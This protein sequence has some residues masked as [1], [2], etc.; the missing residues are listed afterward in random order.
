MADEEN[1]I[2][3]PPLTLLSKDPKEAFE[4]IKQSRKSMLVKTLEK[5]ELMNL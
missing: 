4:Q 5:M 2:N 3:L 1:I